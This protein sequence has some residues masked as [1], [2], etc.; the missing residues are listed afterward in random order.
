MTL[1]SQQLDLR[2]G[3]TS[4]PPQVKATPPGLEGS[5]GA[6]EVTF[7]DDPSIGRRSRMRERLRRAFGKVVLLVRVVHV[8]PK[9]ANPM[10][11]TPDGASS[12]RSTPQ[13]KRGAPG[14]SDEG[15]R[16]ASSPW[17]V[18][19]YCGCN[20]PRLGK[21][22]PLGV[23]LKFQRFTHSSLSVSLTSEVLLLH[24]GTSGIALS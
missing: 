20:L 22:W 16:N 11:G 24:P 2:R 14:L 23:T 1:Q 12:G 18:H 5:P 9:G 15:S 10:L 21:P 3:A 6:A 8:W 7:A 17:M 4:A 13:K 19:F